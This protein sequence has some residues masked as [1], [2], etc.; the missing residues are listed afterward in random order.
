[1]KELMKRAKSPTPHFF[2]RLRNIG[3]ALT[4]ISAVIMAAPIALPALLVSIAGYTAVAGGIASA[5]SQLGIK[6]EE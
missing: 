2:V 5:V 1:M 4:S 3:L 6:K